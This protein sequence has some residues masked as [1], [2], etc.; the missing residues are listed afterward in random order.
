MKNSRWK[1]AFYVDEVCSDKQKIMKKLR[2]IKYADYF[3]QDFSVQKIDAQ[4]RDLANQEKVKVIDNVIDFL[5][6]DLRA[7]SK[8][9][10][11]PEQDLSKEERE[12]HRVRLLGL[13]PKSQ[14]EMAIAS[15]PKRVTNYSPFL[16][17][18][19]LHKLRKRHINL[20]PSVVYKRPDNRLYVGGNALRTIKRDEARA[21]S[22][23]R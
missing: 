16:V 18:I 21:K 20:S 9:K 1:T 12:E 17:D 22:I 10:R 23:M 2:K 6:Q 4:F 13:Q 14:F 19:N 5:F 15:D 11:P 3:T 8:R 7:L